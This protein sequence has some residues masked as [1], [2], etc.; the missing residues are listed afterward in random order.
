MT[1]SCNSCVII[2]Y[3]KWHQRVFHF[4]STCVSCGI[5]RVFHVAFNVC[6]KAVSTC[7]SRDLP[8]NSN[9]HGILLWNARSCLHWSYQA[10]TMR[11]SWTGKDPYFLVQSLLLSRTPSSKRSETGAL[12]RKRSCPLHIPN[13]MVFEYNESNTRYQTCKTHYLIQWSTRFQ[14]CKTPDFKHA[15]HTI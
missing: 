6:F 13:T 7:D 5:K 14:T 3:F 2:M 4:T 8:S 10:L 15:K 9:K 12:Y 1:L 11:R